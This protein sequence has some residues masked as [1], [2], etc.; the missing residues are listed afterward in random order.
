MFAKK[1]SLY[2]MGTILGWGAFALLFL[3]TLG[4]A[5]EKTHLTHLY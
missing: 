1:V 4:N 3:A 5:A 2:G